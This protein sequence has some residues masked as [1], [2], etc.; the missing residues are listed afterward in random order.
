MTMTKMPDPLISALR[1]RMRGAA[2]TALLALICLG[3]VNPAWA[4][5]G[6]DHGDEAAP[7]AALPGVLSRAA[8]RTDEVEFVAVLEP[9]RLRVYLDHA[10]TNVPLAGARVEVDGLGTTAVAAESEPGVYDLK[11]ASAPK[12]GHHPLTVS[13]QAVGTED[14]LAAELHVPASP[15]AADPD[16]SDHEHPEAASVWTTAWWVLA[17]AVFGALGAT[18]LRTLNRRRQAASPNVN[19]GS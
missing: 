10:A 18:A 8:T 7:P 17:G 6:E 14:L 5:G 11:L 1:D 12:P 13:V 2:M 9:G 15:A 16:H 4:H 19:T 3:T